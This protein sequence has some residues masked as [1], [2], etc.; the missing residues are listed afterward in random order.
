MEEYDPNK[1]YKR[2]HIEWLK[3]NKSFRP[4]GGNPL[5]QLYNSYI[6][7]MT[8]MYYSEHGCFKSNQTAYI[9]LKDD[10]LYTKRSKTINEEVAALFGDKVENENPS[11]FV[12]FNWS[13]DSTNFNSEKVKKDVEKLFNKSWVDKARGVFEYHGLKGNHPHF[14]CIIQV[15]KYKKIYDF[16]KKMLES[17]MAYG[18]KPNFIDVKYHKQYHEDYIDLDKSPQKSDCLEKDKLWRQELGLQDEYIKCV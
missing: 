16:K 14:H 3:N 18:L 15:N 11:Y 1:D 12:T 5:P 6:D 7:Y 8:A 13:P 10:Y 4:K 17:A 2:I 9:C